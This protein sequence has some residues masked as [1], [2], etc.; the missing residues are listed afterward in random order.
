VYVVKNVSLWPICLITKVRNFT[1]A[2]YGGAGTPM[3]CMVMNEK[4]ILACLNVW[5]GG[6]CRCKVC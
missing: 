3:I 6:V 4:L 2:G 1:Y 5:G